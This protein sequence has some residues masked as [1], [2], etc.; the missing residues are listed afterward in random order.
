MVQNVIKNKYLDFSCGNSEK[1]LDNVKNYIN[2]FDCPEMTLDLTELNILDATKVMV[3][4]SAYHYQKYPEGK[5]K[6]RVQSDNVK[7]LV[8]VFVTENLEVINT[9]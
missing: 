2:K 9:R 1:I 5:V 6:C 4:S 3:L 7:K 8:A